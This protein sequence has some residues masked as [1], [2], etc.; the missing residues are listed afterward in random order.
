MVQYYAVNGSLMSLGDAVG[1]YHF[2]EDE[3]IEFVRN[4]LVRSAIEERGVIIRGWKHLLSVDYDTTVVNSEAV[5]ES[6]KEVSH[7]TDDSDYSGDHRVL[8]GDSSGPSVEE[9]WQ[10]KTLS[11]LQLIAVNT[12]LD[13][14]DQ[15]S[16]KKKLQDLAISSVTWQTWLKDPVFSKYLHERA[17]AMLGDHQ[18]E[19]QLALL[20]KIRMGDINAI[21][22]YNEMTGR[23]V[24]Q[25]NTGTGTTQLTDFK[26][27]L[28]RILEVINDE[29]EDSEV[30]FRIADRFRGLIGIQAMANQMLPSTPDTIEMPEIAKARELSPRLKELIEKGAGS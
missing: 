9:T 14:I 13:L 29:V 26:Q 7:V 5:G 27:L 22:Y 2:S 15:R 16:E 30:A 18:H 17:E 20:D 3:F 11:P 8:S 1:A 12:M 25:T 23:Y 6:N 19:A 24:P 21:K 28:I 10:E 4:D